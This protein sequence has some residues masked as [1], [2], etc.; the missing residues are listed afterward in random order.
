[1]G[2]NLKAP[3]WQPSPK[4]IEGKEKLGDPDWLPTPVKMDD[5]QQQTTKG[6]IER[7]KFSFGGGV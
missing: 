3:G 1:M 2:T 4:E 5:G 6:C 7:V